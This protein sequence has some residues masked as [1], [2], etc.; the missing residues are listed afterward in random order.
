M[1]FMETIKNYFHICLTTVVA[2]A[3]FLQCIDGLYSETQPVYKNDEINKQDKIP[4]LAESTPACD[5]VMWCQKAL[6]GKIAVGVQG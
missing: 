4:P 2:S 1:F 5:P 3:V 6:R